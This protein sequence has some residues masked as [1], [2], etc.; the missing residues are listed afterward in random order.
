M[1]LI[2]GKTL[3]K[4]DITD[5]LLITYNEK[6]VVILLVKRRSCGATVGKDFFNC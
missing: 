1:Q 5:T 3:L 2:T 6:N 4:T